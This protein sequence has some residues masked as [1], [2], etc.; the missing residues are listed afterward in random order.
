MCFWQ[1]SA[2]GRVLQTPVLVD[3]PYTAGQTPALSGLV[4]RPPARRQWR[5]RKRGCER[6]RDREEREEYTK[7]GP[8]VPEGMLSVPWMVGRATLRSRTHTAVTQQLSGTVT[9]PEHQ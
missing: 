8:S 6:E 9:E 1:P 4:G 2:H 5:G 7:V 3:P